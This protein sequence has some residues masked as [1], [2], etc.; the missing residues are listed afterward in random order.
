MKYITSVD[1]GKGVKHIIDC[2]NGNE[3]VLENKDFEIYGNKQGLNFFTPCRDIRVFEDLTFSISG[4]NSY[5]LA[6]IVFCI[7]KVRFVIEH[8]EGM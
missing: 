8:K 7:E 1:T 6:L 4:N 3:E 5:H 2:G